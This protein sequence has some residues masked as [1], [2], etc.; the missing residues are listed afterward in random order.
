MQ[1]LIVTEAF[2]LDGV[3]YERG[4]RITQQDAMER[5]AE[6]FPS[7]VVR[8]EGAEHAPTIAERTA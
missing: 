3:M 4:V 1:E 2:G 6:Q 8:I 5:I 7:H